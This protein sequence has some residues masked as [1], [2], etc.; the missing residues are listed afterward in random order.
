M[1]TQATFACLDELAANNRRDWFE[2]N[3][4]RYEALVREPA[5]DFIAAMAPELDRFAPH[6]LALHGL[7]VRSCWRPVL[8]RFKSQALRDGRSSA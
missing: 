4:V 1:F 2:A 3:K 7:P 5:L 6:F 8:K